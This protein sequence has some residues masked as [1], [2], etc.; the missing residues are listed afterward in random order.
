MDW[1]KLRPALT[2]IGRIIGAVMVAYAFMLV[3]IIASMQARV[4]DGLAKLT[5]ALDYSSAYSAWAEAPEVD[6]AITR[7]KLERQ[8][9]QSD[10]ETA[11]RRAEDVSMQL[12]PLSELGKKLEPWPG[13]AFTLEGEGASKVAAA[14]VRVERCP[15]DVL[16]S[17]VREHVEEV[18]ATGQTYR[19]ADLKH[20]AA[21]RE[22]DLA[23]IKGAK[24]DTEIAEARE[25]RKTLE[26]GRKG[27]EAMQT[28]EQRWMI[29]GGALTALP[30]YV[31]QIFLAFF[32]GMFGALLVTLVL[33]VYPNIKLSRLQERYGPR[34]MLGGL[35]ALCVFVVLGGGT[36]VL[37]TASAFANGEANYLAFSAICI[38]AG[39]FSDRVA[40]WLSE[41]AASFFKLGGDGGGGGKGKRPPPP[42][43]SKRATKPVKPARP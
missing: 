40:A 15:R 2:N 14:L 28:L 16:P 27:I 42:P 13:C 29:A 26:P 9:I 38:L 31:N 22:A 19:D 11:T 3:L 7:L 4:A 5:P 21:R 12:A 32:S 33:I 6:A 37:G 41:R 36:A 25:L 34:V 18:T 43:A 8:T 39:M 17:A 20:R 24:L 23:N 10:W 1:M 30:P 35:I